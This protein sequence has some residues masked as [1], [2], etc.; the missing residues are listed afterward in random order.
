VFKVNSPKP[1]SLNGLLDFA[2]KVLV[3]AEL[4][5]GMAYQ[6]KKGFWYE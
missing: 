6:I 1:P 5:E 3:P 4:T 2:V